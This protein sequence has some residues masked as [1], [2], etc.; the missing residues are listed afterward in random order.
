[1]FYNTLLTQT[2]TLSTPNFEFDGHAA[3]NVVH[4]YRLL[5][6]SRHVHFKSHLSSGVTQKRDQW[7][8]SN[9]C[10]QQIWTRAL[11]VSNT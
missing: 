11:R 7:Q 2:I 8:A 9:S 5:T 3:K 4:S 6:Y 10:L 1:M